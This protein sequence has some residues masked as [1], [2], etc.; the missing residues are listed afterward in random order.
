MV[1][2]ALQ[3]QNMLPMASLSS[4]KTPLFVIL[5][6]GSSYAEKC[7]DCVKLFS[8]LLLE[9]LKLRCKQREEKVSVVVATSVT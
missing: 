1:C 9:K 2:Q 7:A 4:W 6:T 3:C 5:K 8:V